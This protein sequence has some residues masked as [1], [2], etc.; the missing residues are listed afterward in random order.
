MPSHSPSEKAQVQANKDAR[1][2]AVPQLEALL[3]EEDKASIL[4]GLRAV[5]IGEETIG[6]PERFDEKELSEVKADI[7]TL[8]EELLKLN[9]ADA[10]LPTEVFLDLRK[11]EITEIVHT[12]IVEVLNGL[13]ERYF[14]LHD[15]RHILRHLSVYRYVDT[16]ILDTS[17]PLSAMMSASFWT[18]S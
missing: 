2:G 16:S 11:S 3:N 7:R 4:T 10:G 6:I 15:E 18:G 5:R 14:Y 9:G 1:S 8:I 12:T 13:P 17:S